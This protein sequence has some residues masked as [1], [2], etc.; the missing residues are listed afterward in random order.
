MEHEHKIDV[1]KIDV[2]PDE[3]PRF[4]P[5]E[6]DEDG[7]FTKAEEKHHAL[8]DKAYAKLVKLG[9]DADEIEAVF[10][11]QTP[12]LRKQGRKAMSEYRAANRE[13]KVKSNNGNGG[14]SGTSSVAAINNSNSDNGIGR[15][16][17]K[18]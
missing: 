16:A 10:G 6:V 1:L 18:K 2:I 11:L 4:L 14:K 5:H 17:D 12:E 3:T 15:R 8:L 13:R 7:S 9:L